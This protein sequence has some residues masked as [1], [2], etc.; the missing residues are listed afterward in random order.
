MSHDLWQRAASFAARAHQGQFRKDD[1]T[2]YA[3]HP[4]RVAMTVRQLFEVDDPAVI[5]AALLHDTIEDTTADYDEIEEA[6]G[7]NVARIVACLTKDMRL[8]EQEREQAYDQ[9]LEAGTWKARVIK[10]ADVYDNLT[11]SIA[12]QLP[13]EKLIE[14]AKRAIQLAEN[15]P[16]LQKAS[17]IVQ[18]LVDEARLG[19]R[20]A[21]SPRSEAC[22]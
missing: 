1:K 7:E 16:Q 14:K 11:E 15:D 12:C 20:P 13:T 3:A 18:A 9:Q 8:P 22:S 21:P 10:L 19:E 6:F 17:A 2:P 4:F 5:C